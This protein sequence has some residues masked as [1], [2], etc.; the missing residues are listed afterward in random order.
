[1]L[2]PIGVLEKGLGS[3][4]GGWWGGCCFPVENE[5]DRGEGRRQAKEPAS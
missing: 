3:G 1:M 2:V 4:S 5:G